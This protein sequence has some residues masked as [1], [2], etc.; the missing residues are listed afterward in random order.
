MRRPRPE[1]APVMSHVLLMMILLLIGTHPSNS[2][3]PSTLPGA[4]GVFVCEALYAAI[5]AVQLL[6]P[7]TG[8]PCLNPQ[9]VIEGLPSAIR[10]Q[11]LFPIRG[12]TGAKRRQEGTCIRV[13]VRPHR[14]R[15]RMPGID[16]ERRAAP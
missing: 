12:R 5:S 4:W 8:S 1:D 2:L 16:L 3:V 13:V 10:F 11:A 15:F 9:L 7:T 14:T 6:S